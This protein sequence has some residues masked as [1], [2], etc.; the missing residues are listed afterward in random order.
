MTYIVIE[1]F[2]RSWS[3]CSSSLTT[4]SMYLHFFRE[5]NNTVAEIPLKYCIFIFIFLYLKH[6]INLHT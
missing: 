1:M 6:F 4:P 2:R 5:Y 3:S